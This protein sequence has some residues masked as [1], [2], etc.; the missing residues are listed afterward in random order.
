MGEVCNVFLHTHQLSAALYQ[1]DKTAKEL[2]LFVCIFWANFKPTFLR[3]SR[4]PQSQEKHFSS[5]KKCQATNLV[6][7]VVQMISL[8]NG[9]GLG[10][11]GEI[12]IFAHFCLICTIFSVMY[13]S[14]VFLH[15]SPSVIQN[16][17]GGQEVEFSLFTASVNRTQLLKCNNP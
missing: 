16:C 9:W 5:L 12:F 11:T 3:R 2:A 15:R 13:C 14:C 6:Y 10:S 4:K 17:G 7:L 1:H 8:I